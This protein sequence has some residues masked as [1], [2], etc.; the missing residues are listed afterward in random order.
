MSMSTPFLNVAEVHEYYSSVARG[1]LV[2][3]GKLCKIFTGLA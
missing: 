1:L 2:V 3:H